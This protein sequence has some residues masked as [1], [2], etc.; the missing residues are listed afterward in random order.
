MQLVI[1]MEECTDLLLDILW[2]V[3]PELMLAY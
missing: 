3:S 1:N 2:L